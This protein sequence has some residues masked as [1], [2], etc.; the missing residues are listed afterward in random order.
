MESKILPIT[1]MYTPR[2]YNSEVKKTA[3]VRILK[4]WVLVHI[5]LKSQNAQP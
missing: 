3:L 4:L 1:A 2:P 5:I